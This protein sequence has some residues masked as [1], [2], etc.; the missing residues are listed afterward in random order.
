MSK[1]KAYFIYLLVILFC[2]LLSIPMFNQLVAQQVELLDIRSDFTSFQLT[3]LSMINPLVLSLICLTIGHFLQYKTGLKSIL[4]HKSDFKSTILKS[5]MS[6]AI[7]GVVLFFGDLLFAIIGNNEFNEKASTIQLLGGI[8]YGGVIEE[9]IIRFGSMNIIVFLL[10]KLTKS[11]SKYVYILSICISSLIFA[12]GHI[13]TL[14]NTIEKDVV[15]E[16]LKIMVLNTF[17]GT[18]Y[19]LMYYKHSLEN[20]MLSHISTHITVQIFLVFSHI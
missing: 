2:L 17:A 19:G 9:I 10:I 12:A 18:I 3:L 16:I 15:I 20:A 1:G 8:S 11:K 4:Y 7:V 14:V 6:G 5:I 13:P